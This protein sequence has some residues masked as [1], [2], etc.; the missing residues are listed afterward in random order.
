VTDLGQLLKE[1]R[2]E[3]GITL[4]QLEE[5]TKIRRR[6]LEAIEDG[7]YHVLPGNFYV[8][9]FIKSYAEAVGLDPNEVLRMYRNVIPAADLEP[10]MQPI[11]RPRRNDNNAEKVMKW[12]SHLLVWLFPLFIAAVIYYFIHSSA[13][14]KP[15]IQEGPPITDRMEQGTE[16]PGDLAA[17]SPETNMPP[18]EE[19]E[20]EPPQPDVIFVSTDGTT[21]IYN[22][23]NSDKVKIEMKVTGDRCWVLLREGNQAGK[24]IHEQLFSQDE[25]ASW[26]LDKSLWLRLGRPDAVELK[27]NGIVLDDEKLK[28]S[29]PW[30]V[31]INLVTSDKNSQT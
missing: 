20:A 19:H 13:E 9:A 21:Y 26:E 10:E 16:Q 1:A 22:A 28:G 3:K 30:N 29:S 14:V 18:E 4:E 23:V 11:R 24:E 7:D 25:E 31:Q 12:A 15:R 17:P 8:R 5:T 27:V 6:Y 2:K